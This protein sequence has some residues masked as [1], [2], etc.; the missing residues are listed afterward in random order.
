MSSRWTIYGGDET[1]E[2]WFDSETP[3][4]MRRLG[5]ILTSWER[6]PYAEG[7]QVRGV[8]ADC[9]RALCGVASDLLGSAPLPDHLPA[10]A[11]MTQPESARAAMRALLREFGA[12]KVEGGILRPMDIVVTKPPGRRTGPGHGMLVGPRKALWHMDRAAGFC[13]VGNSLEGHT[14]E[15]IYRIEAL[16]D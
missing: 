6:T 8:G 5:D 15:G 4:A 1:Y 12:L 10:D 13:R 2:F 3:E 9:V 16:W 11:A 14:L 7:S